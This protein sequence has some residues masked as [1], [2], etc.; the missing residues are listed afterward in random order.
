MNILEEGQIAVDNSSI[1]LFKLFLHVQGVIA[2]LNA[3][4]ELFLHIITV[5]SARTLISHMKKGF[6]CRLEFSLVGEVNRLFMK[7]TFE[8]ERIFLAVD[9]AFE[10]IGDAANILEHFLEARLGLIKVVDS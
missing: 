7:V 10:Y 6:I 2:I 8:E 4:Y 1:E 9:E 5:L 3:V